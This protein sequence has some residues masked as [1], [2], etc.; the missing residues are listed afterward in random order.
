MYLQMYAQE[1]DNIVSRS[2]DSRHCA[3]HMGS[4]LFSLPFGRR[5][6][7]RWDELSLTPGTQY[8]ALQLL[9][10][11]KEPVFPEN[12]QKCPQLGSA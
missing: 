3:H 1:Q 9:S 12:K 11:L 4:G 10:S 7:I 5:D 2:P 6:G 8:G